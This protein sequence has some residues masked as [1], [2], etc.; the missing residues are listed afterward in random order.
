[1]SE[2]TG[3]KVHYQL[4]KWHCLS[5]NHPGFLKYMDIPEYIR[6]WD[7]GNKEWQLRYFLEYGA[8]TAQ[9]QFRHRYKKY[10][11]KT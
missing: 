1:M 4:G 7:D 6:G 9:Q 5:R 11:E 3:S 8:T 10:Y 2:P